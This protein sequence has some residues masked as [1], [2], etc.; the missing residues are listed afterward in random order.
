M[1]PGSVPSTADPAIPFHL[2]SDRKSH[3]AAA[4]DS[5]EPKVSEPLEMQIKRLIV[6]ALML[7][8]VSPEDIDTD[9]PLFVEGLGL[10]SIDA[11]ELALAIH[12]QFGV[13]TSP[14][15]ERNREIFH[16]VRSLAEF[17]RA[18]G[19]APAVSSESDS[20]TDDAP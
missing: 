5:E 12:K 19:G 18:G 17:V 1:R 11:L 20:A 15:D 9:A 7:E 6:D 8:D 16:S 2:V 3:I 4:L 13:R 14:D 10:D